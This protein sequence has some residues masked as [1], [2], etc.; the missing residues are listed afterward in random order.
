MFVLEAKLRGSTR[1][2]AIIDEIDETHGWLCQKQLYS[3]L[4]G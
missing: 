3:T 4:D 1:Q 2:F